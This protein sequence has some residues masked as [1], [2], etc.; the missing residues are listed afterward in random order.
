MRFLKILLFVSAFLAVWVFALAVAAEMGKGEP[1]DIAMLV[2]SLV[3]LIPFLWLGRRLFRGE[4]S[5]RVSRV[6]EAAAA[7]TAVG[8]AH[9]LPN[10]ADDMD[11]GGEGGRAVDTDADID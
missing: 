3:V 8:V 11:F 2:V 7:A 10:V 4:G 9:T 6:E 5:R 1:N